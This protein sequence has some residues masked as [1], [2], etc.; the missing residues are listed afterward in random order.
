[1]SAVINVA[2][3]VFAIMLAGYLAGR[4]RILGESS[5]EALNAF[6]YW[7]ALPPVIFLSIATVPLADVFNWPFIWT[8]LSG[9]ALVAIPSFLLARFLF[10]NSIAGLTLHS[11]TGI[12]SN[13]GY[14]GIPLFIAAFGPEGA[15]PAVIATAVNNI[16][17]LGLTILLVEM[18]RG[19]DH[20]PLRVF[21][22]AVLAVVRGPLFLAPLAGIL[23]S[24][25]GLGLAIPASNFFGLMGAAAGPCA[26]FAMGL[27]M[28]GKPI[29]SGAGEVGWMVVA[30]LVAHPLITWW[31]AVEVFALDFELTRGAVL[32]AA[33][34]TGA[35]AFVVAQKYG[36]F[37]QRCSAAILVSTVV[38][39]ASVSALL[40]WF[41]TG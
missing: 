17:L 36:V 33:L 35:L 10:P 7:F 40:A 6:V 18:D 28:V 30:K 15:L 8:L 26:L 37:V 3:P 20:A 41:G 16:V 27:F 21:G 29:A 2:I 1:M 5:S 12:F 4:F 22:Q 38:S 23:W 34:P 39:I 24:W 25:S 31:L 9:M 14:M 11:L 32:M 19:G 13:T